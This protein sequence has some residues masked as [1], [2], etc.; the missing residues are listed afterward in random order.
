MKGDEKVMG[1]GWGVMLR[2][3]DEGGEELQGSVMGWK[4]RWG[5]IY[6]MDFALNLHAFLSKNWSILGSFK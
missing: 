3:G 5:C 1:D 6:L 4:M 2:D